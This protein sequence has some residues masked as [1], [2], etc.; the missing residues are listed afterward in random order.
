MFFF[1]DMGSENLGATNPYYGSCQNTPTIVFIG[2]YP[3]I[4]GKTGQ[5]IF[6][7]R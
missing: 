7:N 4:T 2:L 3:G 5:G 6:P 1:F